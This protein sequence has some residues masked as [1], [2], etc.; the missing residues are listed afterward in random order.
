MG[1]VVA[2]R[3]RVTAPRTRVTAGLAIFMLVAYSGWVACSSESGNSP[4]DDASTD[5]SE[6][7][8]AHFEHTVVD[9]SESEEPHIDAV[10][11]PEAAG[12]D[13]DPETAAAYPW[14]CDASA[15]K[16]TDTAYSCD[17]Y[18]GDVDKLQWPPFAWESCGTG[19]RV[20]PVLQGPN[21][22]LV[23]GR[24]SHARVAHGVVEMGLSLQLELS[25]SLQLAASLNLDA[26]VTSVV[27]TKTGTGGCQALLQ[28]DRT[29]RLFVISPVG[30]YDTMQLGVLPIRPEDSAEW[31][32]PPV[33]DMQSFKGFELDEQWGME[34]GNGSIHLGKLAGSSS[35]TEMIH[36]SSYI[37]NTTGFQD[38]VYWTDW[39]YPYAVLN[40]WTRARGVQTLVQG[41]WNVIKAIAHEDK[42]VWVGAHGPNTDSGSY[43]AV[44]LYWSPF[45]TDPAEIIVH[46]GPSLPV[47]YTIQRVVA[48]GDWGGG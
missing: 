37:T 26:G 22:A 12:F 17:V 8:D 27:R 33:S 36:T 20:A 6:T 11:S 40:S 38:L 47:E 23:W 7:Q 30:D 3:R 10:E 31:L 2:M 28:G 4:G 48:A 45:T 14:L 18:V 39:K 29:S 25:S 41:P 19:C 15:W 42:L 35:D 5:A 21:R 1:S 9:H 43:E 13:V 16:L 24:L 34:V 44:E 46:S 32:V